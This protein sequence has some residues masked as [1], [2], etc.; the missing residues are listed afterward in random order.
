[1]VSNYTLAVHF[2]FMN[3]EGKLAQQLFSSGNVFLASI[4]P[5]L[6]DKSMKTEDGEEIYKRIHPADN[7][8]PG[9]AKEIFREHCDNLNVVWVQEGY[10]HCCGECFNKHQKKEKV[11]IHITSMFVLMDMHN[12]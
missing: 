10:R 12:L 9:W 8:Y 1:M 6:L 3:D 11:Q 2:Q 7:Y 5:N 4:V